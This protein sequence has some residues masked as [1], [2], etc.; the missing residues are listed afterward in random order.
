MTKFDKKTVFHLS[1]N[2]RIELTFEYKINGQKR[3]NRFNLCFQIKEIE[4]GLNDTMDNKPA[5][6]AFELAT[7]FV[8]HILSEKILQFQ[9][10]N[11]LYSQ[12]RIQVE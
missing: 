3:N 11:T 5:V 6:N 12:L 10:P 9:L 1:C 2:D 4:T 7:E 8:K